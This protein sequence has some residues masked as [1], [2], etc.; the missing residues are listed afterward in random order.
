MWVA[1]ILMRNLETLVAVSR[2][3]EERNSALMAVRSVA[4]VGEKR[5][6]YKNCIAC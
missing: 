5:V 2:G 1:G 4:L 3:Q 6:A